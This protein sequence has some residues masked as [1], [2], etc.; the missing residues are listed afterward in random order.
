MLLPHNST[1]TDRD[2]LFFA[3]EEEIPSPCTAAPWKLLIVDDEKEVHS[4]TR[5]VLEDF[6]FD[7]RGLEF[8]S[9]YSAAEANNLLATHPDLAVVLLDVVMETDHSGLDVVRYIREELKNRFLRIILRTGQPGHAPESQVVLEYDI[10]DYKEKT[11]LTSQKLITTIIS[12]LRAYRDLLTIER[13]RQGLE[14]IMTSSRRLFERPGRQRFMGEL[15]N[16]FAELLSISHNMLPG[17]LSGF[18]ASTSEGTSVIS[19]AIGSFSPLVGEPLEAIEDPLCLYNCRQALARR[20]NRLS[21]Q[22]YTGF[23]CNPLGQSN[24]I[25]LQT[26]RVLGELDSGL[27]RVFSSYMGAAIE[28]RFLT[29]EIADTQKELIWTLGEVVENRSKETAHHVR[30]VAEYSTLLGQIHGLGDD[31]IET[32]RLASPMH[33]VGKI[34]V[35]DAILNKPGALTDEEYR[36]ITSHT[37]I[38]HDIL[39]SSRRGVMQAAAII[40]LQ[41]HEYWNGRG[42]PN[43]LSGEDIHIYGRITALVDVFD[44]L[45]TKRV[46][47]G[48]WELERILDLIRSE[49]GKMFDPFLVDLFF[50]HLDDFLLIRRAYP[51]D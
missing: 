27:L 10:N 47:R 45:G 49:R 38:G 50:D 48:A 18:A 51:D 16:Q 28:N 31:E 7:D 26:P 17:E 40:A 25:H 42:Y 24:L 39:K 15:L 11:E 21:S 14:H 44:A 12:S 32:L 41:H 19:S 43:R 13:S 20:E 37:T 30:R 9:A 36:V 8:Y 23:F 5:L 2:E 3:A 35:P 6:R 34:G 29:L 4:I 33:D 46:Y 1:S 22:S